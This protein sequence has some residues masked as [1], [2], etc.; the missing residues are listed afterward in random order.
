MI[1]DSSPLCPSQ[2]V[3]SL[4]TLRIILLLF[5]LTTILIPWLYDRILSNVYSFLAQSTLYRLSIFETLE[6]VFCYGYIEA[7]FI[8]QFVRNPS[9]RI[10]IRR[11]SKGA[12]SGSTLE[13]PKRPRMRRPSRRLS[14]VVLYVAPLLVLDFTLVKKY[15]NVS[16]ADI[17]RSGGYPSFHD[18]VGSNFLA[19]SFH[20]FSLTS[21]LQL[22]RALPT[23]PPSSRRLVLELITA[24]FIYDG[25]FFFAHLAFHRIRFLAY[26]H[27]PH[28][29]HGEIHPQVTDQLSVVERLT[30]VLLANF[31]LN[32][33]GGHVLTRTIFIPVFVYL[34]I[35]IH[36]GM[37]LHFGFEKILPQ[38]WATGAKKHAQH[39]REGDGSFAPFFCW[40]DYGLSIWDDFRR[41]VH[42][43][44]RR[45]KRTLSSI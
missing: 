6:T 44:K 1:I 28:H 26:F 10:D 3:S 19:P 33:I 27:K 34:L 12:D 16:V 17:R 20:K 25:L 35:E 14:E 41:N 21:P 40:W 39:H 4:F 18:S 45:Q 29:Q 38:G 31:S 43:V 9:L 15:A 5:L 24:V 7:S 37:D 36:S 22:W 23:E 42:H 11:T 32:I 8:T 2:S 30:L 13:H